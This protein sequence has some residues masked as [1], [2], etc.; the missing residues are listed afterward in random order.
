MTRTWVLEFRDYDAPTHRGAFAS[1]RLAEPKFLDEVVDLISKENSVEIE[2]FASDKDVY[3]MAETVGGDKVVLTGLWV[4]GMPN[5]VPQTD[6]YY[7]DKLTEAL[8]AKLHEVG[9][10]S[11]NFVVAENGVNR[12]WELQRAGK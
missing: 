8:M 11:T 2:V 10:R 7:L 6:R 12:T 1:S 5:P 4:E 3:L 9:F